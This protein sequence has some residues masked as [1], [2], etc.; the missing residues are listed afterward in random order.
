MGKGNLML[1]VKLLTVFLV[2]ALVGASSNQQR[3]QG[4]WKLSSKDTGAS[5]SYGRPVPFSIVLPLYGNVYPDG[6]NNNLLILLLIIISHPC[7]AY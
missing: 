2:I 4:W 7:L 3:Q 5:S 6:Y 1:M